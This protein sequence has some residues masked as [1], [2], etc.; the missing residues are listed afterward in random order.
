MV[1]NSKE[2]HKQPRVNNLNSR[3]CKSHL[4]GFLLSHVYSRLFGGE[5]E[6]VLIRS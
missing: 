2:L 1:V 6:A 4:W 5:I 3:K